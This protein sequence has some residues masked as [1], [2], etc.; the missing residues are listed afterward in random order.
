MKINPPRK[1]LNGKTYT[2]RRFFALLCL[3]AIS[4][5][6]F[7][8]SQIITGT[9]TDDM[10]EP[11]IGVSV[12]VQGTTNGVATDI[13]GNYSI[14][15]SSTDVLV[16]SYLGMKTQNI[17]VGSQTTINVTMEENATMLNETVVI[18][19]GTAKKQDLTGSIANVNA[20]T[21]MRQPSLS[22]IQAVQGK[23]AGVSITASDAPGSSPTIM[24]RGAGTALGGRNP[25]Y[26]VDGFPMEDI[27]HIS[28]ADIVSMDVLKDAASASIYGVR[29]AN[30][31]VFITTKRG[32]EG[33]AKISVDSY[34]GIKTILNKVK[35]ANA[36]QYVQYYNENMMSQ[37]N[38][39]KLLAPASQQPANTDWYD[40]LLK[41][42]FFNNN[43]VS[44][45]GGSKAVDY[46]LSY[47]YYNE[48]G[49]LDDA[50]FQRSTI[51]NNNVYKLFNDRLKLTQNLSVSF[52]NN[53]PRP[54]GAFNDAYRQSP[55]VP[56]K[57]GS[58]GR[59]GLPYYNQDTG[60]VWDNN[61]IPGNSYGNLYSAGNP[62]LTIDNA[63]DREKTLNLQGGLEAEFKITDY[64]K[65]N[66]RFGATKYYFKKRNF[67]DLK[68]AWLNSIDP[69][70]DA[71]FF[72]SQKET[73]PSSTEWA[74]NSLV[75][76]DLETYRWTWEGFLTFNKSF[77]QHNI[78]AVAGV[79]AERSNIGT[80]SNLKGYDVPNNSQYW[81]LGMASSDYPKEINQYTLTARSLASYFGRIQYNYNHRYYLSASIRYDGSSTFKTSGK[82]RD[83]FPSFG[84]GWT[85]SEEEFMKDV[86]FL[87]FLK[88][89]GTW[90]ELGNQNVPLDVSRI[91]GDPNS[92][93]Y[94]YVFG[95]SGYYQGAA[96]GSPSQRLQWEVTREVG[97]GFDFSALNQRLSGSFDYYDKTN[98]NA[99]MM[100]SPIPNSGFRDSYPAHGGKI[101]NRGIEISLNWRDQIASTGLTYEIGFNY[102]YNKNE[103]KDVKSA[104]D[105]GLGGSLSNGENVKRL[106]QG[107]PLYSFWVFEAD[108]VWQDQAE[109][110]A[111]PHIGDPVPGHLRYKDQNGDGVIDDRD[112]I[113]AG[114][115]MP[116]STYGIHLGAEWRSF[117]FS[118]DGYGVAG[119]KVYNGLMSARTDGGENITKDTFKDRWTGPGSTN[120][121]PGANRDKYPSTYYLESGAFF[122]INNITLGYTLRDLVFKGSRLRVYATA[123]NPF[124]FTDYSGFSPE[125]S[126]Y[127]LD[128][129]KS[130][131]P[132]LLAGVEMDAYP[133]TRSFLFGFNLSF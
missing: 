17:T 47:N 100:V 76:E 104:Y 45:S 21:I 94:N 26:V 13:D 57:Y 106:A 102:A 82:Y 72:E 14:S 103:V 118:I 36:E 120:K 113:Y 25:L 1:T 69:T 9:V 116:I 19:Y 65:A 105:G 8:Q 22:P 93:N 55:L 70:R 67:R 110:N 128:S 48:K 86:A 114:T 44:V 40:E 11:L 96:F 32:Q 24:I 34:V 27:A 52:S 117:D 51:R 129:S 89:K 7:A 18:G 97:V 130:G 43:T 108:G 119:N 107:K 78:E 64:L 16:F 59:Y 68:N 2:L 63:A 87:D 71:S 88:I 35:M 111:N 33:Q 132:N 90:G 80:F 12:V 37:G 29:A 3:M 121:H 133:T 123:Q 53:N 20:E 131:N 125:I 60:I 112:K 95:S 42:G 58:T 10:N 99:I 46:F 77:D 39:T 75:L 49:I 31:V 23:M 74:N 127:N 62:L 79:S 4:I 41:T 61:T 109:I 56:A 81:N 73:N 6:S 84:L 124:M 122:R 28:P 101:N 15:A 5:I 91:L 38:T 115:Y 30:G 83:V 126:G 66:T 50:S 98:T 54:F 85:I 92:S